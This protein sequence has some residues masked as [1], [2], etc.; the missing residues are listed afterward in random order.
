M[1]SRDIILELAQTKGW[2][3]D[4]LTTA[5]DQE[6]GG[7]GVIRDILENNF[8]CF[9]LNY[10]ANA[11]W[12]IHFANI[13]GIPFGI[14]AILLS[15]DSRMDNIRPF[16]LEY[17]ISIIRSSEQEAIRAQIR[18]SEQEA[19]RAQIRRPAQFVSVD[20]I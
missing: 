16:A 12:Y 9:R 15:E 11:R 17:A 5:W 8:G 7:Q 19:I 6:T 1:N 3:V 4:D 14:T 18:S 2:G 20:F 10:T 13:F